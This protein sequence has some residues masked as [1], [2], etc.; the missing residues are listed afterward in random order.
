MGFVK[1]LIAEYPSAA[2]QLIDVATDADLDFALTVANEPLI[3]CRGEQVYAWRLHTYTPPPEHYQLV[4][5]NN[6]IAGIHLIEQERPALADT[7]IEIALEATGLNFRDVLNAMGLYP[8][9]PGPL[10]GEGAGIITRIGKKVT[11]HKVGERVFGYINGGFR[12]YAVTD[13]HLLVLIPEG[14]TSAQAAALP[15]VYT[16]VYHALEQLAKVKRGD[17]VLIHAAAGGVGLAAIAV[18]PLSGCRS[19]CNL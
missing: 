12:T 1:S 10:G 18:M 15:I 6:Q 13:E 8:G 16:T 19:V 7:Q 14:V 4:T 17:K 11:T 5:A 9:D 3:S 2:I